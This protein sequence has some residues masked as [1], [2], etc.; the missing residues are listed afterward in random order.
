MLRAVLLSLGLVLAA[1]PAVAQSAA[2]CYAD[3]KASREPPLRLHYG[4]IALPASACGSRAAAADE[5]AR[6]IR[7][8]GWTLLQVI[9]I[10]GAE[11][12][13]ERRRD[14]GAFHLRY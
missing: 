10:F 6:R 9:S 8:E 12:L 3:Y 4:V 5:I 14:A 13:E 7:A 1:A 2:Q 11:G